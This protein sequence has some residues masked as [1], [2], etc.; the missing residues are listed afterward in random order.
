[1]KLYERTAS[2]FV[3]AVALI[4]GIATAAIASFR[5]PKSFYLWPARL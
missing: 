3:A 2:I 5:T 1:M 4:A